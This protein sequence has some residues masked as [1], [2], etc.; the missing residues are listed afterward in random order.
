MEIKIEEFD[1]LVEL[2]VHG[3]LDSNW[4]D[5]LS[6]AI[7]ESVRGG[8]HRMLLNLRGVSYLS[9]A[10][11]S[12]LLR[13]HGQLTRLHGFFGVSDPSPQVHEILKLT[14]LQQRLICD[15]EAVRR[16]SSKVL[17]TAQPQFRCVAAGDIDFELYDLS[18]E[19]PLRCHAFGDPARLPGRQFAA[20]ETR[21]VAFPKQTFGL[22][23]G[24]FGNGFDESRD[25]FGE[26]LAAGGAAVQL[27]TQDGSAPDYQLARDEFVPAVDVLYGLQCVGDFSQLARFVKKHDAQPIGLSQLAAECLALAQTDLAG[28][29]I[30][31][32]TAGLVGAALRKSPAG[33]KTQDASAGV[34]G[35]SDLFAH[36]G[37]RDWLSFSPERVHPRSLALVVGIAAQSPLKSRA[38]PLAP[39]LRPLSA[40]R[41]LAG[42]FHAAVF[43]Y[44][45]LKK[46]RLD[47]EQTVATL[48]ESEHLSGV[49]HLLGDFR[50]M[51][52]SGESAFVSGACWMAPIVEVLGEGP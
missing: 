1:D 40:S 17:T 47:L 48:F 20:D 52:G 38:S 37:V 22:G 45:P 26:F 30:V 7:D 8:A 6:R 50:E 49:L 2:H 13:A 42:H 35:P 10:G 44:R 33:S 24:A 28:M 25:R 27:P 12:V 32:E 18:A 21:Q 23:L 29:V 3:V 31:A 9:S 46:R 43:S 5:H 11:I 39:M 15:G 51:S 14:G 19:E 4:S 16:T 34:A 41:D 36:P